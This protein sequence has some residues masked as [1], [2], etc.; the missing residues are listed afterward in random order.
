MFPVLWEM[1][2]RRPVIGGGPDYYQDELTRRAMPYL[3][4]KHRTISAHNL[5]LLLLVETGLIGLIIFGRGVAAAIASAWRARLSSL[6]LLPLAM[7]VPLIIVGMA[8][9]DPHYNKVFWFAMAYALA[10]R[11]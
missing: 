8:S 3:L 9:S 1:I 2:L 5:V 4:Q 6:G 11:G 7:F 10:A